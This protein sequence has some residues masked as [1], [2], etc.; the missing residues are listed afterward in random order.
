MIKKKFRYILV[1]T[2]CF[3]FIGICSGCGSK[4][5]SQEKEPD[6]K[7]EVSSDTTEVPDSVTTEASDGTEAPPPDAGVG[8]SPTD[9]DRELPAPPDT[10]LNQIAGEGSSSQ[11]PDLSKAKNIQLGDTYTLTENQTKLYEFT[12][13]EAALTDQRN[14]QASE[15]LN[16]QPQLMLTYTYKNLSPETMLLDDMSFYCL[17]SYDGVTETCPPYYLTTAKAAD[18]AEKGKSCTAEIVFT[19]PDQ[20]EKLESLTVVLS[21]LAHPNAEVITIS[22][23]PKELS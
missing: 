14:E 18:L 16:S 8:E 22:I 21:D 15:D 5:K 11:V 1:A 4:Q 23:D 17:A 19:L 13:N 6:K 2:L 7:T 10:P 3:A 9:T 20:P 12:L